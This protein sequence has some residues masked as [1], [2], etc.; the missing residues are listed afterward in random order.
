MT[1]AE[2]NDLKL[3]TGNLKP[4]WLSIGTVYISYEPDVQDK[5]SEPG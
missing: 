5:M 3:H 4:G 1:R 2:V